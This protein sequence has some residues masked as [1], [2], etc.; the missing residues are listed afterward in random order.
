MI[1]TSVVLDGLTAKVKASP[2]L[3]A[4]VALS[5]GWKSTDAECA[6][7]RNSDAHTSAQRFLRDVYL[8][9]WSF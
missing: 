3:R 6:G 4:N 7:T 8:Y 1:I 2:Q 5:G 9:S